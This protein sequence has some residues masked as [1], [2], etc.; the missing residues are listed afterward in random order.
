MAECEAAL[1]QSGGEA[2]TTSDTKQSRPSVLDE[3]AGLLD[4]GSQS[5]VE[6]SVYRQSAPTEGGGDRPTAYPER[7][8]VV[9]AP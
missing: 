7:L 5:T 6:Y 1:S 3:L 8:Q 2:T 9:I 4:R